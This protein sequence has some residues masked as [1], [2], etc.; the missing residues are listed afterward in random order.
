MEIDCAV[1]EELAPVHIT[2]PGFY[3]LQ[4]RFRDAAGNTTTITEIFE[5][6]SHYNYAAKSAVDSIT[7][8][9]NGQ[10][11]FVEA[12]VLLTGTPTPVCEMAPS[13]IAVWLLDDQGE[14]IGDSPL[15]AAPDTVVN[16]AYNPNRID[17]DLCVMRLAVQGYVPS[18]SLSGNTV[19]F[20]VTGSGSHGTAQEFDFISRRQPFVAEAN[21]RQSLSAFAPAPICN[22]NTPPGPPPCTWKSQLI[23]DQP[24]TYSLWETGP[25][26]GRA[27]SMT[28]E[29]TYMHGTASATDN[30][31]YASV[32]ASIS[33][34]VA[35]GG[36]LKVFL[37]P[38][39]CC[40]DCS[41][42]IV[43]RPK[44]KAEATIDPPASASAGGYISVASPCGNANA[45]GGVAIGDYSTP[46]VEIFG[47]PIPVGQGNQSGTQVF[48]DNLSCV[49][50]SCSVNVSISTGAY[51]A[52]NAHSTIKNW[53][54][55]ARA[56][57]FGADVGLTVTPTAIPGCNVTND[58][59]PFEVRRC[60]VPVPLP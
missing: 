32:N 44:F 38:Q 45:Q 27:I 47:I 11:D 10:L 25:C 23:S 39:N 53:I 9:P 60:P 21:A 57:V 12:N 19:R 5:V 55:E 20:E 56:N 30:C 50:H 26:G 17:F 28:A 37:E 1:V 41:I 49:E 24:D 3:T 8:T 35:S 14:P 4:A 42:S 48:Q 51:V 36:T 43:A 52:V 18:G 16:A 7:I 15:R 40:T 31:W 6:R 29:A 59:T 22:C 13:T 54:A 2:N 46:Y 33:H 58:G 34:S